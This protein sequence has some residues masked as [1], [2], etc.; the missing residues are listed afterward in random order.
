MADSDGGG[1]RHEKGSDVDG[2]VS[3]DAPAAEKAEGN[4]K[5]CDIDFGKI[6]PELLKM[7]TKQSDK[8]CLR[9][10]ELVASHLCSAAL[11]PVVTHHNTTVASGGLPAPAVAAGAAATADQGSKIYEKLRKTTEAL[12]VQSSFTLAFPHPEPDNET[13][14]DVDRLLRAANSEHFGWTGIIELAHGQ[15]PERPL[16]KSFIAPWVRAQHYANVIDIIRTGFSDAILS[17]EDR[18][19]IK[20]SEVFVGGKGLVT[21][22][23]GIE[24]VYALDLFAIGLRA[25]ARRDAAAYARSYTSAKAK[26]VHAVLG[27]ANWFVVLR[28]RAIDKVSVFIKSLVSATTLKLP[29]SPAVASAASPASAAGAAAGAAGGGGGGG[30]SSDDELPLGES[31]I[32]VRKLYT[33]FPWVAVGHCVYLRGGRD[34]TTLTDDVWQALIAHETMVATTVKQTTGLRTGVP[35]TAKSSAAE[36]ASDGDVDVDSADSER[37]VSPGVKRRRS[38]TRI[39]KVAAKTTKDAADGSTRKTKADGAAIKKRGTPTDGKAAVAKARS[40]LIG[41]SVDELTKDDCVKAILCFKCKRPRHGGSDCTARG[42][43]V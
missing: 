38:R 3:S 28:N 35:A 13:K 43:T 17:T 24:L 15:L 6:P 1:A 22:D 5:V 9:C 31:W 42:Q 10:K 30:G 20:R 16:R 11:Q 39:R 18:G 34:D 2:S 26:L 23:A 19:L 37:V 36:D 32:D 25:V 33:A 40:A 27:S 41:K 12:A 4:D 7:Y 21:K 8:T 14:I 29:N